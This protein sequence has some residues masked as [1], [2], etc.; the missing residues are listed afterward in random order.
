[1]SDADDSDI[2]EAVEALGE[3]LR[4]KA[5]F[6][7]LDP[8]VGDARYAVKYVEST[9]QEGA[10][11]TAYIEKQLE[12]QDDEVLRLHHQLLLLNERELKSPKVQAAN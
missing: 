8:R 5:G 4:L 10:A 7:Q 1:M 6:A 12:A 2:G 3:V 9:I 11:H